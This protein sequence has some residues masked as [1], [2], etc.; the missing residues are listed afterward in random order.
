MR[1][2]HY[3]KKT[4]PGFLILTVLILFHP[5]SSSILAVLVLTD[6]LNC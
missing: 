2:L 4:Q 6:S 3:H 1:A 5:P